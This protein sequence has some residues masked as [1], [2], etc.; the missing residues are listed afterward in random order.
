MI[1]PGNALGCHVMELE[2]PALVIDRSVLT[3]NILRVQ[4]DADEHE[5]LMRP[6][7]KTHKMSEVARQQLGAGAVGLTCS[8]LAEAEWLVGAGVFDIFVAYPVPDVAKA[9]RVRRLAD[10]CQVHLAVDSLESAR[11]L[12]KKFTEAAPLSVVLKIDTG[13]HRIGVPPERALMMAQE[14]SRVRGIRLTG[15]CIHEGKS[16]SIPDRRERAAAVK[17]EAVALTTVAR[18]IEELGIGPMLVSV[19]ATPSFEFMK[20]ESGVDELRPGN[21]VFNDAV[22]LGLGVA[23][24]AECALTVV[25]SVVGGVYEDRFVVDCGSKALG[26][27]RGAHGVVVTRGFAR[28]RDERSLLLGALSEEHGR[29]QVVGDGG[30][31]SVGEKLRFI[32]NHACAVVS[33]FSHAYV[34]EDDVVVDIYLVNARGAQT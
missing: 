12:S 17:E 26:L 20:D 22:Q 9:E 27:D 32:P 24:D 3:K 5:K 1:D 18:S 23:E 8:K 29:G 33:N 28:F 25:S 34:V 4:A 30:G 6:H 15:V 13:L 10:A 2:T 19:G 21:Y 31:V 7:V 11:V 16:Y 14:L